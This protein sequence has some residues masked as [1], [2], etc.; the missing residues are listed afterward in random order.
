[1]SSFLGHALAGWAAYALTEPRPRRAAGFLWPLWLVFVALFPDLDY[2]VA[3]LQA[4]HHEGLRIT[5]SL[6]F[7]LL[8]PL[9]TM[10][11]LA[12]RG[13]RGADLRP[14]GRQVLLAGLSHLLLDLLVGVT[15]APLLWPLSGAE[16]R[17]PFGVLP[18]AGH[19]RLSNPLF[20]R[21][22][23]IEMGAL[24]PLAGIV[25]V[26]R[27]LRPRPPLKYA[28]SGGLAAVSLL[29]MAWAYSLGR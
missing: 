9:V 24:L 12:L 25:H 19:P 7:A 16:F 26:A 27:S 4:R 14:R 5:H 10:A 1:M 15:P 18:S 21:N 2:G 28:M 17:L 11:V 6:A 23:L 20:Y 8:L 3:A 13:Y 29:F 22:L